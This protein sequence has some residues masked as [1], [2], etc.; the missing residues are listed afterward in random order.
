VYD[1]HSA[2]VRKDITPPPLEQ[3]PLGY[4]SSLGV[5]TSDDGDPSCLVDREGL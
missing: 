2:I 4:N 3:K 5:L 1:G